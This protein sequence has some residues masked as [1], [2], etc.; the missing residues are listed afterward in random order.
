MRE[1]FR[2]EKDNF[3]A[4]SEEW[5][6]DIRKHIGDI[7]EWMIDCTDQL[8]SVMSLAEGRSLREVEYVVGN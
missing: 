6:R 4:I 1:L 3:K 5:A 8:T 7:S 2:Y